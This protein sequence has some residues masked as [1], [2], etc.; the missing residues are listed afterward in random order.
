MQNDIKSFQELRLSEGLQKSIK[1]MGY[2]N[3]TPIQSGAIPVAIMNRDLIACAQTGTGKT[4]AFCIPVIAR[5]ERKQAESAL[6]LVPT[7]EIASQVNKVLAD[8]L[9]FLPKVSTVNIV[10]GMPMKPQLRQ[11]AKKP[12]II[13]ATPGRLV[14]HLRRGSVSLFR[15]GILVLDE[16]DRMLDMGFSAQLS[17]IL[18]F[19]P[20]QRQTLLYSATFPKDIQKLAGKYLNDPLHISIGPVAKPVE[21]IRQ[22]MIQTTQAGKNTVLMNEIS[23]RQGSILIFTRTKHRTD[24]L[25]KY[26]TQMGHQAG[27][28]HGGRSQSQRSSALNGFRDG[29]FKILVATDIAARGID[30]PHIA[31]VINYDLPKCTEDY[32]HRVGRTAR[33]G[34]TGDALSLV[35]PEERGQWKDISRRFT[36]GH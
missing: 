16:A 2:V 10:G 11:L 34:A 26:L 9:Q 5:L 15:T 13:I 22:S 29:K 35:A 6:I 19:L 3:P 30:V 28:I 8:F 31:H 17:E 25:T 36:Q 27:R 7:R 1:K 18:R 23:A 12:R 21:A 24:R 4:A 32:I 33:A 14:D 20:G